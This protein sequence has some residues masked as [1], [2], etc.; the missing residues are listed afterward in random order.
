MLPS[1]PKIIFNVKIQNMQKLSP[2]AEQ[3]D[4]LSSS[5]NDHNYSTIS[6]LA[7]PLSPI[8]SDSAIL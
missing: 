1:F 8:S 3:N 7:T 4:F 5:F 6:V 2:R